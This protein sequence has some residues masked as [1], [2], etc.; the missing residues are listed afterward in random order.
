MEMNY[1]TM[2]EFI[3]NYCKDYSLYANDVET[4]AKMD[5][6][7]APDFISTAYFHMPGEEY[8]LVHNSRKIFQEFLISGHRRIKDKLVPMQIVVDEKQQKVVV[9]LLIIKEE[10]DTGI[11]LKIDGTA[12]YKLAQNAEGSIEIKSLDF[13]WEV[14]DHIKAQY[15][16]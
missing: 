7:W 9:Q 10:R 11:T 6:Y 4:M 15:K 2:H 1:D 16:D 8:P 13:F 14:P 3:E 5:R 12:W